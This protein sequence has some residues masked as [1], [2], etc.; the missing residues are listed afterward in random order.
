MSLPIPATVALDAV[1]GD[2]GIGVTVAAALSS[3]QSHPDLS[4]V[5]VGPE[6]LIRSQL[7]NQINHPRLQIQHATE[8]VEMEVHHLLVCVTAVISY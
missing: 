3:L 1:G 2:G 7:G 4:L 6:D 8:Y 5:L